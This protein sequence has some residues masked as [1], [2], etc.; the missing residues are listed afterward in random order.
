[1]RLWLLLW[2]LEGKAKVLKAVVVGKCVPSS[3]CVTT[4]IYINIIIGSKV[5]DDVSACTER[6]KVMVF[7][8][9]AKFK[10]YALPF[11]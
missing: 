10:E 1:M 5:N 2:R 9:L 4:A 7:V 6:R 8:K 11:A 3:F